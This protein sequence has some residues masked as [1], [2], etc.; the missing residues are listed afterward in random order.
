MVSVQAAEGMEKNRIASYFPA[1][2]QLSI[3]KSASMA[4]FPLRFLSGA[5]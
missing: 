2:R 4:V 1:T 5:H 3:L